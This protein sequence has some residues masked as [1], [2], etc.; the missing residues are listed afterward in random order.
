MDT[1]AGQKQDAAVHVDKVAE[2]VHVG[3]G[4]T[5][6]STVIEQD[7]S[8]QREVHQEV[9]HRQVDGVDH[10]RGL[11]LGAETENIKCDYVKHHAHLWK[12]RA[13]LQSLYILA[14][15]VCVWKTYIRMY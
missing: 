2:D 3:A 12:R 6:S 4:E 5:R 13:E 7:T 9:R 8:W 15:S 1:N 11:L 14:L 10:W